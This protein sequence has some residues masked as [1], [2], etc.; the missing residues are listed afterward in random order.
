MRHAHSWTKQKSGFSWESLITLPTLLAGASAAK[1]GAR[2]S[3]GGTSGT[4]GLGSSPKVGAEAVGSPPV[5]ALEAG[6]E[7]VSVGG[8]FTS[9][10]SSTSGGGRAFSLAASLVACFEIA[11]C[12]VEAGCFGQSLEAGGIDASLA[13]GCGPLCF[14]RTQMTSLHGTCPLPALSP[15]LP[16]PHQ[17]GV[18]NPG[19]KPGVRARRP[20]LL[21][22]SVLIVRKSAFC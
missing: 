1:G 16:R 22:H 2:L 10:S 21:R 9:R 14:S 11:G 20:R 8:S 7:V 3:V 6:R 4:A 15:R 12:V 13:T 17:H 5:A 19:Q 18:K